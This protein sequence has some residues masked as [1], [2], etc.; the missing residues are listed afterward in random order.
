LGLRLT[1]QSE[2][3]GQKTKSSICLITK[4]SYSS[5]TEPFL[6]KNKIL[7]FINLIDFN[8]LKLMHTY[9]NKNLPSSINNTWQTNGER[10]AENTNII[11]NPV[12]RNDDIFYLPLS[13]NTTVHDNV[14]H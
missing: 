2:N 14:Y 4:P 3:V 9:V 12:L 5:H 7:P 1:N 8:N 13:R 10:R 6:K 11:D